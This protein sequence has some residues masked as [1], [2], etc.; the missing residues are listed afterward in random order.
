M[1]ELFHVLARNVFKFSSLLSVVEP[2]KASNRSPRV[3]SVD[4]KKRQQ[5][6]IETRIHF[7]CSTVP[8]YIVTGINLMSSSCCICFVKKEGFHVIIHRTHNYLNLLWD[9]SI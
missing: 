1:S 8:S 5:Q 9:C 3:R 6:H 4:S 7:L 2:S